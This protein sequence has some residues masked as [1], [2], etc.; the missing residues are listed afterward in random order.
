MTEWSG[1]PFLKLQSMASHLS[2][3]GLLANGSIP[4]F[5]YML[6]PSHK[7]VGPTRGEKNTPETGCI[8]FASY[9][10]DKVPKEL[11]GLGKK[12]PIII[13][14]DLSQFMLK[15][16]SFFYSNKDYLHITLVQHLGGTKPQLLTKSHSLN[17]PKTQ[18]K[19]PYI[20]SKK[21]IHVQP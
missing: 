7:L 2:Y 5:R 18:Y 16:R 11:K 13:C 4:Y 8:F 21:G 10:Q 19:T 17:N 9:H 12:H 15:V 6:P 3:L 20:R 14:Q 1:R